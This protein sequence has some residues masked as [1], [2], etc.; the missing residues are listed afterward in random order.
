MEDL[1]MALGPFL[2]FFVVIA[3]SIREEILKRL[4]N[5]F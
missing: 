2:L 1:A 4:K 5:F 3:I